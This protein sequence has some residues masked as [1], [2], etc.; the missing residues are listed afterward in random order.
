MK[1]VVLAAGMGSR[2][3]PLTAD[4]PKPLVEVGKRPLLMRTIDR[5]AEVGIRGAD[6]IIVSGYR[7]DVL[8]ATL[9]AHGASA[10]VV[11]NDRHD[12]WNNFWSA[13]VAREAVGGASFLQVDGDVLFDQHVLPKM[14]AADGPGALSVDFRDELDAE[15]M[16]VAAA[17]PGAP[18]SAVSKKLDPAASA[19]EYIGVTR[20]DAA[21]STVYF[22]EL[23]RLAD[24]G[25]INEY[26]EGAI[27]RLVRRGAAVFRAV[28]VSDCLTI[29]IDDLHDLRRAEG[30]LR[31]RVV[32]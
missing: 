18:M 10:T 6:V 13:R 3:L 17:A 20:I 11:Y 29:E 26:Y 23:A 24:E 5:L 27:D 4:R 32:A 15:T 14:L 8:R 16:K 22:D 25:L 12:T 2:L 31:D 21:I 28:D 9:A 30:L 1:A 7:D 19:G